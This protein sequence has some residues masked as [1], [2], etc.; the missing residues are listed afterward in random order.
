MIEFYH[1]KYQKQ[2]IS[3]PY[4]FDAIIHEICVIL[5]NLA[6]QIF[7]RKSVQEAT[8]VFRDKLTRYTPEE[9]ALRV[10]ELQIFKDIPLSDNNWQDYYLSRNKK[11]VQKKTKPYFTIPEGNFFSSE[12]LL[13]INMM[14]ERGFLRESI[15]LEE[16]MLTEIFTP[17]LTFY[18]RI[19]QQLP[20]DYSRQHLYKILYKEFSTGLIDPTIL[21]RLDDVAEFF[22]SIW[23]GK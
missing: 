13:K 12:R 8:R 19:Q 15:Y 18:N 9:I 4:D 20:S 6:A 11:M 23:Q 5:Y 22:T 7:F 1:Q 2:D 14:Y 17:F 3:F 16:W 10:L 21:E